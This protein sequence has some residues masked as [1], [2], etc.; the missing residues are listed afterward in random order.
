MQIDKKSLQAMTFKERLYIVNNIYVV[1][2]RFKE[3][4]LSRTCVGKPSITD[5][6]L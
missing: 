5:S 6:F 3:I 4:R 2:P 1:Y